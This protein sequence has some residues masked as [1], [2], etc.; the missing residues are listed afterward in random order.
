MNA[1]GEGKSKPACVEVEGRTWKCNLVLG[2]GVRNA[3]DVP[4][5]SGPSFPACP[6]SI[7]DY[8]P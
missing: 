2:K 5:W 1:G 7:G 8:N 4:G 6:A 3:R